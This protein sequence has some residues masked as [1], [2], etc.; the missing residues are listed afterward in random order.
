[1]KHF[2]SDPLSILVSDTP[3]VA[4]LQ[5]PAAYP[6]VQSLLTRIHIPSKEWKG[7]TIPSLLARVDDAR[8]IFYSHARRMR[9][10]FSVLR[11]T[12]NFM[13]RQGYKGLK[14]DEDIETGPLCAVMVAALRGT[15]GRSIKD[16]A[17]MIRLVV[18]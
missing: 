17:M 5:K 10:G 2:S 8:S 7:Q 9:V 3:P 4:A 16:L 6:F 11:L 18:F 13:V 1:M 15:L 12:Q 14:W